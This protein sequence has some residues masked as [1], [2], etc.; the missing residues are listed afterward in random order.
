[1]AVVVKKEE[2]EEEEVSRV[3]WRKERRNKYIKTQY[4]V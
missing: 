1:M 2:E 4:K 3:D